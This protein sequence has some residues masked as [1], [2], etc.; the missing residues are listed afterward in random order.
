MFFGRKNKEDKDKKA[1]DKAARKLIKTV[2]GLEWE[3]KQRVDIH[4]QQIGYAQTKD[5]YETELTGR[6]MTWTPQML[7]SYQKWLE[8]TPSVMRLRKIYGLADQDPDQYETFKSELPQ[9]SE[10]RMQKVEEVLKTEYEWA[11]D[12]KIHCPNTWRREASLDQ[13][14]ARKFGEVSFVT[15]RRAEMYTIDEQTFE[16]YCK[17]V[18]DRKNSGSNLIHD[19]MDNKAKLK[20]YVS[21]ESEED[22]IRKMLTSPC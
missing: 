9:L 13:E 20:G 21:L 3:Q 1:A 2:V 6:L 11:Q 4:T 10:E 14:D 18:E 19:I 5:E 16:L 12:V 22:R 17:L 7:E 8:Q 15:A